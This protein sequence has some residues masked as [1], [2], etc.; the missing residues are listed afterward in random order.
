MRLRQDHQVPSPNLRFGKWGRVIR[1][2]GMIPLLPVVSI[3]LVVR[4]GVVLTL[5]S[6]AHSHTCEP[7]RVS[8]A[9]CLG[10]REVMRLS[11]NHQVPSSNLRFGAWGRMTRL[12]GMIPLLPL[13]SIGLVVRR[14]GVLVLLSL[15]HHH[16]CLPCRAP[17]AQGLGWTE[18]AQLRPPYR[19]PSSDSRIRA[20]DPMGSLGGASSL[21]PLASIGLV[22]RRGGVWVLLS[23][24]HLHF[25][26]A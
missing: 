9:R 8:P 4:R 14:G 6:I 7:S 5:S 13:V 24:A 19:D 21:S 22:V 20:M 15:A 10:R 3:G 25:P 12:R 11:Q 1:L 26:I 18:T 2:R 17:N 23:L 16:T